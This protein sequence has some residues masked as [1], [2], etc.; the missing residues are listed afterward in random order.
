MV[1]AT[2]RFHA[3]KYAL[4]E[5][6]VPQVNQAGK[7]LT[8]N[9]QDDGSLAILNN[10]RSAHAYPTQAFYVSLSRMAK[11]LDREALVA[12]R[13]KRL[14]SILAKL[15]DKN[16][17]KLSQMQ[18]IGG[19]RA[20]LADIKQVRQLQAIIQNS[21]W[22]HQCLGP[23]DYIIEPKSSGYRGVHLK[24][25]FK[26]DGEK[27]AYTGLKIEIQL[28]TKLQHQWA[29]AVEAADTFTRQAIKA[30]KGDANWRRFFTLMSSVYANYEN[31]PLVPDTPETLRE[32]AQELVAIDHQ[33]HIVSTLTGIATVITDGVQVVKAAYYLIELDPVAMVASIHGF[34]ANSSQEAHRA[35]ANA[36]MKA[37]GTSGQVVLVSVKTIDSLRKAYPNYFLDITLFLQDVVNVMNP[38]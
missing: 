3:M 6:S 31:A 19:C 36:E 16:K 9:A 5:F 17:M 24:Y 10:W 11:S 38:A 30:S 28:R 37:S 2:T 26:G 25:K 34:Q 29:T 35:Y 20:V 13:I 27:L 21:K 8:C 7:N 1:P 18:D 23:K 14:P 12:Q 33:H 4:P 22:R 15:S 32:L